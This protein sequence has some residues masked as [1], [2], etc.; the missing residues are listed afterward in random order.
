MY[1]RSIVTYCR[2]FMELLLNLKVTGLVSARAMNNSLLSIKWFQRFWATS[3][4]SWTLSTLFYFVKQS[5]RSLSALIST[6]YFFSVHICFSTTYII[7]SQLSHRIF[8][9]AT[10]NA[11]FSYFWRMLWNGRIMHVYEFGC[12]FY[13]FLIKISAFSEEQHLK[14]TQDHLENVKTALWGKK[15]SFV[16]FDFYFKLLVKPNE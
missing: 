14:N 5:E 7:S 11:L 10:N 15:Y 12:F 4:Q 2:S 6:V 1:D 13:M 3:T 9:T 16:C 8:L